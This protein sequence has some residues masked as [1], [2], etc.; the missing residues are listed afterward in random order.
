MFFERLLGPYGKMPI[1]IRD[2]DTNFF[3][4]A[5][6]LESI[7]SKAWEQGFKVCLSVVPFQKG[8]NDISVPPNIRTTNSHFSVT[9]N[10]PLVH[11]LKDKIRN[12]TIEILQHG[13]S[14][15]IE[16]DGRGEFGKDL[17]KKEEI[18]LG[19]NIIKQAFEV[20]PKFFVPPGEDVSK[21][22]LRTLVELGFVP[23]H[24]QTFFDKFLR[25]SFVPSHIKQIAMRALLVKYKNRTIDGNWAVQF[26]KPVVI[27]VGEHVISWSL[28]SV[29]SANLSSIDSLFKLTD[30][31]IESCSL[32]RSP[33]CIINHY[34]LY[35]YDWNPSITRKDLF[36]A[37]RQIMKTF[38]KLTFCWKVTF[39]ELYERANQIQSM[40][41]VKTGSKIS[42]Q[43]ETHIPSF[44][45]RTRHPIEPNSSV[46][47]DEETDIMTIEDLLP[48]RKI[49][50]YE[51]S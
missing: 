26:V 14:H 32:S 5:N 51:K 48:Q 15:D 37:W 28:G 20:D 44:S 10:E 46:L 50:V 17:D 29:K 39:S 27:S 9:D 13:F 19:R 12:G 1:L 16:D 23:I 45:F 8:T 4:K 43:S 40:H 2:D 34:H 11:Y 41:I 22:S 3:T 25:N 18:E 30:E 49:I 24:R 21:Q 42:I 47:F 7:Y 31:I 6:M 35:Y 36:Q 33:V 38:D